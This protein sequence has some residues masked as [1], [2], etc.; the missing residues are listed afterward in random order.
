M[1]GLLHYWLIVALFA[2]G[3]YVI[4]A[5]NNLVKKIIGLN[6][7]QSAVIMFYIS[8]G[9]V[10]GGTAPI[11]DERFEIY[12]NPVPHVLMLTAIVVGIATTALALAIVVRIYEAYQTVEE[13]E[14]RRLEDGD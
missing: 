11:L 4:M 7:V 5:K 10:R 8:L 6:V 12:S 9:K 13:D 1:I 14:L 3:L 2:T